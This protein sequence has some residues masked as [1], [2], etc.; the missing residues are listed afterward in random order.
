M[1]CSKK[2][3]T[4]QLLISPCMSFHCIAHIASLVLYRIASHCSYYITFKLLGLYRSY[5]LSCCHF[6]HLAPS[7]YSVTLLVSLLIFLEYLLL[8]WTV[9]SHPLG[10]LHFLLCLLFV[11]A[12]LPFNYVTSS[13][14]NVYHCIA[15]TSRCQI[16]KILLE[17]CMFD[18]LRADG[19][20][21]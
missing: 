20:N 5:H 3:S 6:T 2:H 10:T 12:G 16:Y 15:Y 11:F 13:T 21:H 4:S 7:Y 8:A 17:I 14:Q 19:C 9:S 1:P 18:Q